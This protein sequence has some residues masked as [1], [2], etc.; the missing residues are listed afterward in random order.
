MPSSDGNSYSR[1]VE[2]FNAGSGTWTTAQLS[3]AR[4]FIAA[5]SLPNI[6]IAMFASGSSMWNVAMFHVM[7]L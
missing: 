3:Q 6:G 5:S 4:S 7:M 1:V 2:I